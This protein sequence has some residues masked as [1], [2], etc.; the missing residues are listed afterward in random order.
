MQGAEVKYASLELVA[1]FDLYF[2]LVLNYFQSLC[3][4]YE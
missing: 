2:H 3:S 1:Y 4:C